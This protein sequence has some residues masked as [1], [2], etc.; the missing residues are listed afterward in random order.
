MSFDAVKIYLLNV[1]TAG[2]I[3]FVELKALTPIFFISAISCF[4][5]NRYACCK[6]GKLLRKVP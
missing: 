4:T 3:K 6:I 1:F 5:F 2:Y